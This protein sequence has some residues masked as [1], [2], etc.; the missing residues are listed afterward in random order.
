MRPNWHSNRAE[1]V[2]T[3][4]IRYDLATPA[5]LTVPDTGRVVRLGRSRGAS[6]TRQLPENS[7]GGVNVGLPVTAAD[8]DEGD[9]LAHSLSGT[10][11]AA[12]AIS[13]ATGQITT[14]S[15]AT[16]DYES[17]QSYSLTVDVSDGNGGTL[18]L[19]PGTTYTVEA[20]G[21]SGAGTFIISIAPQ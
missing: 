4:P 15:S 16:Y 11:A 3:G 19:P 20:A 13:G 2:T 21:T 6:A 14:V 18:T 5:R 9:T 12:F 8:L 7:G 17:K 1:A 10:D